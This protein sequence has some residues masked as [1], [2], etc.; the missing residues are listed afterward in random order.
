[1]I[2]Q[3]RKNTNDPQHIN[4]LSRLAAHYQPLI[5][6]I[7]AEELTPTSLRQ[8][9]ER[10]KAR[11]KGL[12]PGIQKEILKQVP[13]LFQSADS[14]LGTQ[15]S[16]NLIAQ[17]CLLR[18]QWIDEASGAKQSMQSGFPAIFNLSQLDGS[19]WFCHSRNSNK[20]MVRAHRSAP[21]GI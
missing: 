10:L 9:H 18:I 4:K 5:S 1:M 13:M 2:E 3:L 16:V 7:K 11:M 14:H 19:K 17:P 12:S 8:Q 6:E 15:E 21:Q 20:W